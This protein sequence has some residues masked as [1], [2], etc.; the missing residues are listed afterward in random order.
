[1][2][3]NIWTDTDPEGYREYDLDDLIE[4]LEKIGWHIAHNQ[5]PI[6]DRSYD[7]DFWHDDYDCDDSQGSNGL[8]GNAASLE[9]AI[10]QIEA[11]EREKDASRLEIAPF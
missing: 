4:A 1:M 9:D 10:E 11:I 5:K 3:G 6:P 7:Y 8:A 2:S